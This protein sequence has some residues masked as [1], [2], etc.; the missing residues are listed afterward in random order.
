MKQACYREEYR[1]TSA[2]GPRKKV[3]MLRAKRQ[4]YQATISGNN[5]LSEVSWGESL[6]AFERN[7]SRSSRQTRGKVSN[8]RSHRRMPEAVE[9]EIAHFSQ[10]LIRRQFFK[11]HAVAGHKNA[12]AVLAEVAMHEDFFLRVVAEN[13]KELRDLFVCWRRPL[14]DRDVNEV[15]SQ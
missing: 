12:G 7:K 14:I 4:E 3:L 15:N 2:K 11:G 9:S 13:R 5:N 6:F 10:G 1:S 8:E